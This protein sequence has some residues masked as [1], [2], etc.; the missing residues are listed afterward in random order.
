MSHNYIQ[1]FHLSNP[2]AFQNEGS[3]FQLYIQLFLKRLDQEC[4]LYILLFDT[5]LIFFAILSNI[6]LINLSKGSKIK[7]NKTFEK[8]L[9]LIG[10]K[11]ITNNNQSYSSGEKR[12]II[13]VNKLNFSLKIL[14]LICYEIIYTGNIF[15]N[16]D[17][18]FI[19]NISEDGWFGDSIGPHQHFA[20]SI[21]RSVEYGRYTLRSANNGISAIIDPSGS[22]IDQLSIDQ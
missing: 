7:P 10:L 16:G 6:E 21:F 1:Y 17:F 12:D 2:V 5:T 3:L 19:V 14:P 11:T 8:I 18:D 22:I 13:E 4:L 20:H 15:K 9:N